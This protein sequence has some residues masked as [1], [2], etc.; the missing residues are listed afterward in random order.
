MADMAD[1]CSSN[2]E[3]KIDKDY[4]A[5]V[6]SMESNDQHYRETDT[7]SVWGAWRPGLQCFQ[8]LYRGL[9]LTQRSRWDF[10]KFKFLQLLCF[11]LNVFF[12]PFWFAKPKRHV[13]ENIDRHILTRRNSLCCWKIFARNVFVFLVQS[14]TLPR[15]AVQEDAG[16]GNFRPY[17]RSRVW[18]SGRVAEPEKNWQGISNCSFTPQ[19][20]RRKAGDERGDVRRR[21]LKK[22]PGIHGR[23]KGGKRPFSPRFWNVIFHY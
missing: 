2:L 13:W 19:H 1:G 23:Q 20:T 18:R 14:K 15:Q 10:A 21:R 4:T 11:R 17:T 12:S 16:R 5:C 3:K 8:A 6:V 9:R 22:H 7:T